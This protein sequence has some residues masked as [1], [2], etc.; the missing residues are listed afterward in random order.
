[1]GWLIAAGILFCI[2][3]IPIG[4]SIHYDAAGPL[5][6]VIAGFLRFTVFPL[7]KK[8]KKPPKAPPAQKAQPEAKPATSSQPKKAA[9]PK[10]PAPKSDAKPAPKGGSVLDFLPLV[11]IGLQFLDGFRRKLR[12]DFLQL[13]W[14]LAGDDPCDLALNYAR[15]WA[16][17]GNL[18]PRLER[19]FTIRKR[20]IEVEC[21]FESQEQTV[22]AHLD[23]TITIGR[24]LNL[25]LVHGFAAVIAFL[26]ILKKRKGGAAA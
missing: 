11:E 23:L 15:T 1:M 13:K 18:L 7:P 2:G 16:A 17:I 5:V 4:V 6:R 24:L 26:R 21:D 9:A 14:I 8:T 12:V 10:E 19:V 25:A 20:D 3:C 22:I